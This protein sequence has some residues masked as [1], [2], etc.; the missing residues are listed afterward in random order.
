MAANQRRYRPHLAAFHVLNENI[1]ALNEVMNDED[2][3]DEDLH[4][5]LQFIYNSGESEGSVS[6]GEE[7]D[8]QKF[9]NAVNEAIAKN[10]S[11]SHAPSDIEK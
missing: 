11:D 3:V 2:G 5:Q 10:D 4:L 1:Y 7:E 6:G 8:G 9:P